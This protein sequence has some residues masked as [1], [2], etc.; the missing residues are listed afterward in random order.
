MTEAIKVSK[1]SEFFILITKSSL[2]STLML[3]AVVPD[4]NV[5]KLLLLG[6]PL[7]SE[8]SFANKTSNLENFKRQIKKTISIKYQAYTLSY[9]EL[10]DFLNIVNAQC[11]HKKKSEHEKLDTAAISDNYLI[12][13]ISEIE[14]NKNPSIT[15]SRILDQILCFQNG[16]SRYLFMSPKYQTT[17]EEGV[18]SKKSFFILPP[19]PNVYQTLSIQQQKRLRVLFNKMQRMLKLGLRDAHARSM[20]NELKTN[21]KTLAGEHQLKLEELLKKIVAYEHPYFKTVQ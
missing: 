15:V 1:N 7:E 20:F 13:T 12:Q 16:V 2:H 17:L 19:T 10:V 8:A 11:E 6:N 5:Q 9:L 18:P 4:G 21:Y 3:G 14:L